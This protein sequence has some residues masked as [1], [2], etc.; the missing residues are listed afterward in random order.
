MG[1]EMCIRDRHSLKANDFDIS[2][3]LHRY[4]NLSLSILRPSNV[5][6]CFS[7][8]LTDACLLL[9]WGYSNTTLKYYSQ[10]A[11]HAYVL[12]TTVTLLM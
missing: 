1:S 10:M 3:V 8:L 5:H 11:L 7:F 6:A 12:P 9:L 2:A 4:I